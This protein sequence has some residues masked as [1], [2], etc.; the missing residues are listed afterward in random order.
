MI[1]EKKIF[2]M[3]VFKK[4]SQRTHALVIILGRLFYKKRRNLATHESIAIIKKNETQRF[5]KR[6]LKT[7]KVGTK[8]SFP[9]LKTANS[10]LPLQ[11]IRP[12]KKELALYTKTC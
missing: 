5:C 12:I 3:N 4:F 9:I 6:P 2:P 8:R 11:I 1:K 10:A 7:D